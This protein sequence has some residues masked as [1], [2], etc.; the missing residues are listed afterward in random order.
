MNNLLISENAL[1]ID[2]FSK[3]Q[4]NSMQ[5]LFVINAKN[6]VIG[7]LTD[8]DLRQTIINRFD[9]QMIYLV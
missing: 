1:I 4:S 5:I 8:G 7:T 3:I 6:E 2:A 9:L